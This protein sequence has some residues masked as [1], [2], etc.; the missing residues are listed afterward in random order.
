[1]S[2][3]RFFSGFVA[4][5]AIVGLT[6]TLAGRVFHADVYHTPS[7]HSASAYEKVQHRDA[8][9][10]R[11]SPPEATYALLST[12]ERS[13]DVGPTEQ[14]YFH[15]HYDFLYNRPPPPVEQPDLILD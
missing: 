8:D 7:A 2:E 6:I 12:T 5:L 14:V 15:P 11:W 13:P 10:S 1:M 4:L 9:A 3:R